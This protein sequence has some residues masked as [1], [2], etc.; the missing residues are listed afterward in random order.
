MNVFITG[1]VSG[2]G[3]M[4]AREFLDKGYRVWG[5]DIRKLENPQKNFYYSICDV[6]KSEDVNRVYEEMR[7]KDFIPDIVILNAGIMKD[8]MN[9]Q[10]SCSIFKEVFTVNLFGVIN[11]ID[12]FLPVFLKRKKGIFVA[13]SSLSAYRA[14]NFNKIAYP[15]SKAALSM[16]F[17]AFRFQ[18]ASSG[19]RFITFHIGRMK[20]KGK[21]LQIS[22][23]KAAKKIATH[24]YLSR[25]ADVVDFPFIP[26]LLTKIS[27]YFP[28][29]F[30]SRMLLKIKRY[31]GD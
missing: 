25:K 2:L 6:T 19:L 4:L 31:L 5:V 26:T 28:D 15:S 20:E 16:V 14:I 10:F 24:L 30:I 22:Y 27:K 8:D 9:Y 7:S 11:W 12:M 3:K 29:V 23:Q 18:L 17:Q 1:V 13:I 21:L